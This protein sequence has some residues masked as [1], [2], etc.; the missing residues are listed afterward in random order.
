MAGGSANRV[1]AGE[2]ISTN[3]TLLTTRK[4]RLSR[5][6]KQTAEGQIKPTSWTGENL[7]HN[8]YTLIFFFSFL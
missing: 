7:K 3:L 4:E 8:I 6:S 2:E 1:T 5:F